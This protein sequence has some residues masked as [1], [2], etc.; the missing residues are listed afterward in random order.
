[1]PIPYPDLGP[2][3]DWTR[4]YTQKYHA[5]PT[6]QALAGYRNARLFLDVLKRT[7]RT[8]T[9]ENFIHALETMGP[10][11]DPKVGGPPIV[12]TAEDHIG[13]RNL[14]LAQVRRGRWSVVPDAY[15]GTASAELH[16]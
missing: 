6:A 2:T 15:R 8:P 7:G 5:L 4:R 10:W 1:V 9:Q 14:F 13:G 16:D 12:F 11:T 3:R